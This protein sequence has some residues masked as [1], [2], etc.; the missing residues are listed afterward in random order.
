VVVADLV[1]RQL[2]PAAVVVAA[3]IGQDGCLYLAQQSRVLLA[4]LE[5]L[6]QQTQAEQVAQRQSTA[7]SPSV[8]ELE[9]VDQ[10]WPLC[11]Q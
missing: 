11:L 7:Q 5:Q 10:M 9:Q 2:E 4:Q 1:L 6:A 8:V 3:V